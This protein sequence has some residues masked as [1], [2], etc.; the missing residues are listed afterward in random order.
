[1][2][3]TVQWPVLIIVLV[4]AALAVVAC[5]GQATPPPVAPTNT[6][7]PP[8]PTEVPTKPP[9]PTDTPMPAPTDT[10]VPPPTETPVPAPTDTPVPEP[11]EAPATPVPPTEEAEQPPAVSAEAAKQ[12][13]MQKGCIACHGANFEGG[14][15]PILAGLPVEHSQSVIRNG[16]PEAGMPAFD[17]N[18]ISDEDLA[19]LT[20]FLNSLTLEAIGVELPADV[21]GHLNQAWEAVQAGDKEAA[22]GFLESA[23]QAATTASPGIQA[24]LKD[25]IEDLEEEDWQED[26]SAHLQVLLGR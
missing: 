1:M 24:T 16:E 2:L 26:V 19:T 9:P 11:T 5:G 6:P 12:I 4:V 23:Q 13:Y 17:Q 21:I 3:K 15:G 14:V 10:P 25:L 8:P 20:A 18:L 22:A 7:L